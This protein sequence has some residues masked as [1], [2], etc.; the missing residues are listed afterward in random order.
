MFENELAEARKREFDFTKIAAAD[1]GLTQVQMALLLRPIDEDGKIEPLPMGEQAI[2]R[3]INERVK[4]LEDLPY[5]AI[6]SVRGFFLR[7]LTA[8]SVLWAATET[9]KVHSNTRPTGLA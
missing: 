4:E 7:A 1:Y 2:E 3:Y 6:L 8:L 9:L 5:S